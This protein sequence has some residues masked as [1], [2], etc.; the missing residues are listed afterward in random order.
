MIEQQVPDELLRLARRVLG[1]V[2]LE[3]AVRGR[4]VMVTGAS[5]GIGRSAALKIADAGGIVLLVARTPEKLEETR[6]LIERRGH[7]SRASLRSV[8]L[9]DIDRMA[10]E[11][12]ARHGHVDVLVN[13]AGR[14][15]RRSIALSY[16][17]F[18]DFER[19]MQ[20]NDSGR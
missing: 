16:D 15:I 12:L 6:A 19:T 9:D 2:S 4:V 1:P 18:H 14:S 11:V 7:R 5:S 8:G 13:N 17:R 3:Q 10:G 20:L